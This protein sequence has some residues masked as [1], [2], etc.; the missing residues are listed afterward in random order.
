MNLHQ[1]LMK[2]KI[3]EH[4]VTETQCPVLGLSQV[5]RETSH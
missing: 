1:D 3:G 5:S 4:F 2:T